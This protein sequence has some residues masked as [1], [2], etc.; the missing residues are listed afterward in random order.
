[1]RVRRQAFPAVMCIVILAAIPGCNRSVQGVS[2]SNQELG[3]QSR[4]KAISL[5][6]DSGDFEAVDRLKKEILSSAETNSANIRQLASEERDP[7]VRSAALSLIG[8][9]AVQSDGQM[10]ISAANDPDYRVAMAALFALM[11]MES[12]RKLADVD[13]RKWVNTINK[14]LERGHSKLSTAIIECST[15]LRREIASKSLGSFL[16]RRGYW[17]LEGRRAAKLL[18]QRRD[19]DAT[20]A[21]SAESKRL[22]RWRQELDVLRGEGHE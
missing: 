3:W 18:A 10:L 14:L 16:N 4:L 13:R 19:S 15:I 22:S 5:Y 17:S 20:R 11:Q 12:D 7:Q 2:Q 6:A 9:I 8:D 21:L 1:M